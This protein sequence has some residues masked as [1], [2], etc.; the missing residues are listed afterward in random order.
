MSRGKAPRI[1]GGNPAGMIQQMQRL[2]Q[3]MIKAQEDLAN[4]V[5]SVSVGGGAVTVE[6]TGHQRVVSIKVSPEVLASGDVEMLNDLLMAAVNEA[7][8]TSQDRAKERM[9][10]IT[11]G[12]QIPGLL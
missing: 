4:E 10:A 1:P 7:I 9:E 6:I 8:V 2:Q 12:I 11:G 5:F 3:D